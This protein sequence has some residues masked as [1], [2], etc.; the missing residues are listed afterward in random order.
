[1]TIFATVAAAV[2]LKPG[3]N[4]NDFDIAAIVADVEKPGALLAAERRFA[5]MAAESKVRD[6]ELRDLEQRLDMGRIAYKPMPEAERLAAMQRQ[7]DL[8]AAIIAAGAESAELIRAVA[9]VRR[10]YGA[11]VRS[12]LAACR[13][14]AAQRVADAL[15]EIIAAQE[16]W[17]EANQAIAAAGAVANERLPPVPN[18][19]TLA[20]N[21]ERVAALLT[22]PKS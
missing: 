4:C 13:A 22:A 3:A 6:A 12:A 18:A 1:M 2:G 16:V 19:A 5:E 7:R 8:S 14:D 11:A 15:R 10:S 17:R 21:A 20:A 9:D